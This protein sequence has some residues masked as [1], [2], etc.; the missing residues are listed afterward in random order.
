MYGCVYV[1][2]LVFRSA[3]CLVCARL[4]GHWV[5]RMAHVGRQFQDT[6][7]L[8]LTFDVLVAFLFPKGTQ[9]FSCSM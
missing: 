5:Y 4:G 1:V 8:Q 2:W 7:L 3:A 6:R 9:R